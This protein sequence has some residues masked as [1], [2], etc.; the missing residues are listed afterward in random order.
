MLF[1]GTIFKII[2]YENLKIK[3]SIQIYQVNLANLTKIKYNTWKSSAVGHTSSTAV[4]LTLCGSLYASLTL[5]GLSLRVSASLSLLL[6]PDLSLAL[7][8]EHTVRPHNK[9]I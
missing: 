5:P 8:L 9:D 3:Y 2:K 6:S 7:S 4:R 1:Y